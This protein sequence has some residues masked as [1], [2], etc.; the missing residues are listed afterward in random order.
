M[1]NSIRKNI[2]R[3]ISRIS[4][5]N[6]IVNVLMIKIAIIVAKI[7][8]YIVYYLVFFKPFICVCVFLSVHDVKAMMK[9]SQKE[10]I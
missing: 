8:I 10:K 9:F 6:Y 7:G 2:L 1:E 4:F 3:I 5:I